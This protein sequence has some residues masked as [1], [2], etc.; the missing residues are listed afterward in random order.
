M[1]TRAN[2]ELLK[3]AE[4]GWITALKAP[5]TQKLARQQE[6]HDGTQLLADSRARSHG[7]VSMPWLASRPKELVSMSPRQRDRPTGLDAR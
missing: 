6:L 4:V 3:T 5:Q 2:L 1:V 7:K